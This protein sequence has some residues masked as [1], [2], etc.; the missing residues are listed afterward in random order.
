MDWFW[1]VLLVCAVVI[2]VTLMWIAIIVELFRRHDLSGLARA[3][4]LVLL[5][6]LPLIGSFLYVIVTWSRGSQESKK[7][8]Y[9]DPAHASSVADLSA[10]DKER[11]SGAI[12]EDEFDQASRRVLEGGRHTSDGIGS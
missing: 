1:H 5:F 11:R 6:F 8:G 7:P 12:T 4:W 9:V 3:T 2:P 10:L